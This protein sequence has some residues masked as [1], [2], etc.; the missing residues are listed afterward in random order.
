MHFGVNCAGSQ[1]SDYSTSLPSDDWWY[2][3]LLLLRINQAYLV[4]KVHNYYLWCDTVQFKVIF[5]LIHTN[6]HLLPW[7]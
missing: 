3:E 5:A 2:Q 4:P 6:C 1:V 7:F